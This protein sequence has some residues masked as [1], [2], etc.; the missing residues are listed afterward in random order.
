MRYISHRVLM[1][2][3]ARPCLMKTF[4]YCGDVSNVFESLRGSL[5]DTSKRSLLD[6]VETLETTTAVNT[7]IRIA[8]W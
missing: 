4:T 8:S 5:L 6:V 1:T 2:V 7:L 3:L